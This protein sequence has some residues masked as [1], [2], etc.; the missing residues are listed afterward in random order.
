VDGMDLGKLIP[1]YELSNTWNAR[2]KKNE[3][4]S[5]TTADNKGVTIIRI[6]IKKPRMM[7][8]LRSIY[9]AIEQYMRDVEHVDPNEI[10]EVGT[11]KHVQAKQRLIHG[12]TIMFGK[13]VAYYVTARFPQHDLSYK[14]MARSVDI[15]VAS[16]VSLEEISHGDDPAF[17]FTNFLGLIEYPLIAHEV[18]RAN[19][20]MDAFVNFYENIG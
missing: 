17:H 3:D 20:T 15:I 8:F 13:H 12:K 10:I 7:L 11:K 1:E 9:I 19:G 6:K 14:I 5:S 18:S 4:A 16:G 2:R